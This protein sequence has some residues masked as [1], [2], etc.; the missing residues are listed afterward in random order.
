MF[1]L[2]SRFTRLPL[3][4]LMPNQ[5]SAERQE[6][7][8]YTARF[9]FFTFLFYFLIKSHPSPS[10]HLPEAQALTPPMYTPARQSEGA[11]SSITETS[12]H[13]L[14][15]KKEFKIARNSLRSPT[16][17]PM[18]RYAMSPLW[19]LTLCPVLRDDSHSDTSALGKESSLKPRLL[20]S[21]C[22]MQ[23]KRAVR[24][25][26]DVLATCTTA[27]ARLGEWRERNGASGGELPVPLPW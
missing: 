5:V 18:S 15:K 26:R 2:V 25:R 11:L 17:H 24:G 19:H 22:W 3:T 1:G 20:P 21:Q 8:K 14:G 13:A 16:S 7:F 10:P 12:T 9:F 4:P 23:S 6:I 27:G